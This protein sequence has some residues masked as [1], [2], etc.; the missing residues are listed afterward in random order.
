MKIRFCGATEGVTGSCH[1]LITDKANVLLD[2]GQFQGGK[3]QDRLNYREFPFEPS[4]I[5]CL[6]LSHAHIDH[7]G[8]IPLLVKRGFRGNI[9]C[10]KATA[11]LLPIMLRD[12]GYIHEKEAE[13]ANKKRRNEKDSRWFS[14]CTRWRTRRNPFAMCIR[15]CTIS[16]LR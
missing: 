13:W 8:R 14:R 11:D 9:F 6:V 15:F 16:S 1:L 2:C 3:A 4:E 10:T 12:S 5:D 7:C